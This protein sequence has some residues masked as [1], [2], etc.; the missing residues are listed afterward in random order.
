M[1]SSRS[2][3]KKVNLHHLNR[4]W[5]KMNDIIIGVH[6]GHSKDGVGAGAVGYIAE[7]TYARKIAHYIIKELR[8]LGYTVRNTTVDTGNQKEVLNG[9]YMKSKKCTHNISIHLNAGGGSGFETL[10]KINDIN[11]KKLNDKIAKEVNMPNR[12]VKVRND[13]YVLNKLKNCII[14]ECGFVDRLCDTILITTKY[15]DIGKTIARNYHE[16]LTR[17]EK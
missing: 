12:G 2:I 15:K 10:V 5:Y 13:L 16:Y 8:Q 7:S 3:K 6:A 4:G 1:L 9:I 11:L 14:L 17:K